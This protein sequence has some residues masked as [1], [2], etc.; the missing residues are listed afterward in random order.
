MESA[1]PGLVGVVSSSHT[2]L[3]IPLQS[4]RIHSEC[5]TLAVLRL[6]GHDKNAP[7]HAS[8]IASEHRL[9][10]VKICTSTS[11][12]NVACERL[13]ARSN[14]PTDAQPREPIKQPLV[15]MARPF[16]IASTALARE[17]SW[18]GTRCCYRSVLRFYHAYR[19]DPL[20]SCCVYRS[21]G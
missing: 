12:P 13:H 7:R 2:C 16:A 21:K 14:P 6:P 18:G 4:N 1:G 9:F 19:S 15:A 20:I 3:S 11:R 8:S 5:R 17:S 10:T